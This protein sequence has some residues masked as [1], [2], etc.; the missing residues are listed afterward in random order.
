MESLRNK[1]YDVIYGSSL[2]AGDAGYIYS[3]VINEL[4]TNGI[5]VDKEI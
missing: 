3:A 5:D 4:V 2:S 1:L